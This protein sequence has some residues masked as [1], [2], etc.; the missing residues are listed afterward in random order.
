[1]NNINI[2]NITL[3]LHVN[4]NIDVAILYI[5]RLLINNNVTQERAESGR[6]GSIT[7]RS[8]IEELLR[9]RPLD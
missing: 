6:C 8:D 7:T 1:M 4:N 2:V 3:I 9:N 5:R